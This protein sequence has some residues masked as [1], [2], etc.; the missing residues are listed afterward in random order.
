MPKPYQCIFLLGRRR[1]NAVIRRFR[2]I[3]AAKIT[4]MAANLNPGSD[5]LRVDRHHLLEEGERR[6]GIAALPQQLPK[7]DQGILLVGRRRQ[8]AAIRRFR[9]LQTRSRACTSRRWYLDRI[10]GLR[11]ARTG[12]MA[13]IEAVQCLLDHA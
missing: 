12:V 8:N 10:L 11:N 2:F 4:Q 13:V 7:S 6:C 3:Q 5:M 1:Q 9:F